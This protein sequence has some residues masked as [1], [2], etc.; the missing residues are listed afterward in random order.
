PSPANGTA[1]SERMSSRTAPTYPASV[2]GPVS[3]GPEK[4]ALAHRIMVPAGILGVVPFLIFA[5]MF[6]I[7]PTAYLVANAF[8]DRAGN[9]TFENVLGL[10]DPQILASFWI[11]IRISATSAAIG[12]LFGLFITLAVIRGR[13]PGGIRST[14]MT[15]SG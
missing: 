8:L 13:L 6:L 1:S 7:A 5:V 3:T 11:S 4:L 12:A 9:L 14:I 10:A 15:F 2:P